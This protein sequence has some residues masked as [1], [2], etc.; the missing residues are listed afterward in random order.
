MFTQEKSQRNYCFRDP[1]QSIEMLNDLGIEWTIIG[2][3]YRDSSLLDWKF[4]FV[5]SFRK[6]EIQIKVIIGEFH[7]ALI[8]ALCL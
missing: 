3:F 4:S 7:L 5:R 8:N 6:K 2:A 1:N